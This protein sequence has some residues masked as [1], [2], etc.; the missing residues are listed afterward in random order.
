[1]RAKID[2]GHRAVG[3]APGR[4]AGSTDLGAAD[5]ET[6]TAEA[7]VKGVVLEKA[8]ATGRTTGADTAAATGGGD[9]A[10]TTPA[11]ADATN[12]FVRSHPMTFPGARIVG[13]GAQ[14][15]TVTAV[16]VV[17]G[18]EVAMAAEAVVAE[19]AVIS[20][21]RSSSPKT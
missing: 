14:K 6:A 21:P 11:V 20:C 1:M 10:A 9:A 17:V 12:R 19:A 4:V 16:A 18:A 7:L 13:S 15:G 5:S 8:A 3:A 2:A